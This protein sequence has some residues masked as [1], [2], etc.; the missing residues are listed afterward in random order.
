M[1]GNVSESGYTDKSSKKK[2]KKEM[3]KIRIELQQYIRVK[4]Q[5]GSMRKQAHTRSESGN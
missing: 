2:R 1:R 4:F 3:A 5:R